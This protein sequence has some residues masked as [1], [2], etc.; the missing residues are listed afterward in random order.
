MSF[1]DEFHQGLAY[2]WD[3]I[4]PEM[5]GAPARLRVFSLPGAPLLAMTATATEAEIKHMKENL[6]LRN[7][8]IILQATPVQDHHKFIALRRPPTNRD[9][10]GRID[11]AGNLRPGLIQLL[12]RIFLDFYV[13]NLKKCQPPKKGIIF[14][15][16]EK[17][18][19]D[20]YEYVRERLPEF[21]DMNTVSFVM[22]H[23]GLGPA[24]ISNIIERKNEISLFLTTSKMLMGIDIDKIS[25]VIFVRPLNMI[26]YIL[27]G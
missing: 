13:D 12:D 5:R 10:E 16:A 26:H 14:F 7:N 1:V 6:G 17:N 22:N 23:S 19:L 24:T 11:M 9:P 2:H 4:R 8:T 25:V 18:M 20:I 3:K 21:D 27:Q 15:R